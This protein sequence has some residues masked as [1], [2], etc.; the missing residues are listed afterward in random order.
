M[1]LNIIRTCLDEISNLCILTKILRY[2]GTNILIYGMKIM[3]T[4]AILTKVYHEMEKNA[5]RG[6]NWCIYRWKKSRIIMVSTNFLTRWLF[7]IIFSTIDILLTH[8]SNIYKIKRR[9][10]IEM[11]KECWKMTGILLEIFENCIKISNENKFL[12][13]RRGE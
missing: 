6:R 3:C 5:N 8:L 4:C 7:T 10:L 13:E 1:I 9:K 12:E 11:S 2:Y